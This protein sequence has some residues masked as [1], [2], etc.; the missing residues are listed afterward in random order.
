MTL[1]SNGLKHADIKR[2]I[3]VVLQITQ[4]I[5]IISIIYLLDII[6]SGL[7]FS[8]SGILLSAVD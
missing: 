8:F 6:E 7:E 1:F 4:L 5:S 3:K 2:E